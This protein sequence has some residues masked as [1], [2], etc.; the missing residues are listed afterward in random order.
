MGFDFDGRHVVVTGGT[1]A[2]GTAVV[3]QVVE[4]G[5]HC[6]IPGF[7]RDELDRFPF[8][9]HEQVHIS[10]G[11]D[12]T[13]EGAVEQFYGA[14]P[15]LWASIHCAGGF[16]MNDVAETPLADLQKLLSM[17]VVTSF[18]CTREAVKAIRGSRAGGG[19]I[20]NVSAQPGIEPRNAG[21]LSAY[22]ASKAAVAALTLA[23][24][25]EVSEE[26]IWVNAIAPSII[27]T[28][29]NRESMPDE[30]HS[31]W[32]SVDDVA[33]TLLFLASP[34]NRVTR[35]AVVPVYGKS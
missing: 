9:S 10:E 31:A 2:L 23:V 35:A 30:D 3:S 34:D 15:T 28:P 29:A 11:V 32:P 27:D 20:V 24:S 5:G 21:G 26:G 22:A 14:L 7:D 4:G 6:H 16:G 18:L 13:D 25:A 8:A 12:L 19:R 33:A 1:G 17:N